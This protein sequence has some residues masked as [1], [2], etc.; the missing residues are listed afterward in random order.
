M[1][2]TLIKE[3]V[4]FLKNLRFPKLFFQKNTH[5]PLGLGGSLPFALKTL[6]NR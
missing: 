6:A 2:P 3:D 5:F 1:L 4:V